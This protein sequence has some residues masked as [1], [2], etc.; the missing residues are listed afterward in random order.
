MLKLRYSVIYFIFKFLKCSL[1]ISTHTGFGACEVREQSKG[2]CSLLPPIASWGLDW[3]CQAGQQAPLPSHLTPMWSTFCS[4]RSL[5]YLVSP[6]TQ[7]HLLSETQVRFPVF[8]AKVHLGMTQHCFKNTD[9][10]LSWDSLKDGDRTRNPIYFL[11]VVL[12]TEPR[13]SDC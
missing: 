6:S 1:C 2:A 3:S 9:K 10:E 11:L 12:R 5:K 8:F 4:T 7:K 13:P